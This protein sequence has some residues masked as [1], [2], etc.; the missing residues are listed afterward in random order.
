MLYRDSSAV[1]YGL[2]QTG[3]L[4]AAWSKL[5]ETP[6]RLALIIHCIRHV[7]GDAV[8][9]WTCDAASMSAGVT[10][11]TWFKNETERVYR[12]LTEPKNDRDLRQAAHWIEQQGGT[13]RTRDLVSG[14]RDI[15]DSEEADSL[16]QRLVNA[17]FGSWKRVQS[18]ERGGRPT[19]EFKLYPVCAD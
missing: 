8:D 16:L 15:T 9:P 3:N 12:L 19:M 1:L 6:A 10:L 5:E 13:V 7:C 11:A 14:R 17:G 18:T 2:S 4:A